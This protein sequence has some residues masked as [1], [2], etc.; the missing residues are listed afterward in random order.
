MSI[1]CRQ[2]IEF[3]DDYLEGGQP[4]EVRAEFESH[5]RICPACR[6]YL[7]MYQDTITLGKEAFRDP[8][9]PVPQSVPEDLVQ[10]VLKARAKQK[11]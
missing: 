7:R 4:A 8:D 9:G 2:F 10:A 3:L 5:F 11:L 1:T 6:D